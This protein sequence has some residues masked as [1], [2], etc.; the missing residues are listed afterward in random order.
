M[1]R[2]NEID[3][4]LL[5]TGQTVNLSTVENAYYGGEFTE[6]PN[7]CVE[8]LIYDTNNNLIETGIADTTDYS[9]DSSTG[10][11]L[12]TGTI[13]RKMGYDRGKYVVKY[14]FLRKVAGSYETVLVDSDGRIFNGNNYHIMDNGKIMTGETHTDFSKELFL[15]EYKYFV[16]EISPSRTEIRVAPQ[17]I[18]D[19]KYKNNFLESQLTSKK[20]KIP[21]GSSISLYADSNT[22]KG[23]SK[24]M[25]LSG[26]TSLLSKQMIGGY[27]SINNAF[28]KEF[29]PPPPSVDGS[30]VSSAIEELESSVIQAQFFILDDSL[31][32]YNKGDR[33]FADTFQAFKG[34]DD[35]SLPS[36]TSI[37]EYGS[38]DITDI[39][40]LDYS[41]ISYPHYN[42]NG[43]DN[44][45]TITLKSNS[46]KPNVPTK[47]TWQ[48]TGWDWDSNPSGWSK[49][50]AWSTS[51]DEGDVA[52][53]QPTAEIS[54]PLKVVQDSSNGSQVT[55]SLHSKHINVGVKL[56]IEPLDGQASTIHIPA[57][58][59]VS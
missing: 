36:D 2:L 51:N 3:L 58:I 23:D 16:H 29:L 32:S 57:C 54:S 21:Q 59:R 47:Y 41:N 15:K 48:L 19:K 30:Q 52:F 7:D 6:N 24:T 33:T 46:S 17:S 14:N 49:I 27:V 40:K 55:I 9:Y 28:I 37:I 42:W 45:N 44:P 38:K 8:V 31:A 10:I 5:Q 1:S 25:K 56:T 20:I 39:R 26:D 22:L 53:V 4:E 18:D 43:K 12:N 13:L 11:K 34:L 50:T 35:N